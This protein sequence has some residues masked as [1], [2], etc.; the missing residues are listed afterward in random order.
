MRL[1]YGEKCST[2]LIYATEGPHMTPDDLKQFQEAL[3]NMRETSLIPPVV[4]KNITDLPPGQFVDYPD[5]IGLSDRA[6]FIC[7]APDGVEPRTHIGV[8]QPVAEIS[9][10]VWC[11][12]QWDKMMDPS[13]FNGIFKTLRNHTID[14][15]SRVA[16]TPE[17]FEQMLNAHTA[18]HIEQAI[19]CTTQER[20]RKIL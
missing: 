1:R 7:Y 16:C 2:L 11:F 8:P 17:A 3:N 19:D 9:T 4:V 13:W 20:P 5:S 12:M 10:P 14:V 6:H 18:Q 15:V